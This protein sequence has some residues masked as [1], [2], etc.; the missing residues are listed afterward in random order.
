M[1]PSP[2]I[3]QLASSAVGCANTNGHV[4]TV[5][6][7]GACSWARGADP[8]GTVGWVARLALGVAVAA[9]VGSEIA[10]RARTGQIAERSGACGCED[11]G[12]GRG[13]DR[14]GL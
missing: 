8:T 2:P 13:Q 9:A 7:G 1:H 5:T 6:M 12:R 10:A 3:L 4:L 11:E 14:G